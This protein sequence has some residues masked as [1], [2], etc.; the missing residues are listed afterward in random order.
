MTLLRIML[1]LALVHDSMLAGW[2]KRLYGKCLTY[3]SPTVNS[4][5]LADSQGRLR[6]SVASFQEDTSFGTRNRSLED[7]QDA[8]WPSVVVPRRQ[9]TSLI[10]IVGLASRFLEA[11]RAARWVSITRSA[12]AS[13]RLAASIPRADL[14]I[15]L[16]HQLRARRTVTIRARQHRGSIIRIVGGGR[17]CQTV[18]FATDYPSVALFYDGGRKTFL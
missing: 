8:D 10:T 11:V 4:A 3:T 12:M 1:Q 7:F 9:P 18:D 2:L 14:V 6:S 17:R 15:D 13:I 5:H 16:G